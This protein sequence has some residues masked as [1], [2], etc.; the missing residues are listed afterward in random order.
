MDIDRKSSPRSQSKK[1]AAE[2]PAQA[3]LRHTILQQIVEGIIVTDAAGHILFVNEA[4]RRLH[5]VAELGVP[6]EDYSK[7][8]H[9]LT[10][11]GAPYP[12][13]RLPLARAVLGGETVV[14]A[15][16]R[17][18]RPDGTQIV[19][20]GSATPIRAEEGAQSG[21]VLVLRDITERVRAE[22]QLRESEQRF[23]ALADTAPVLIWMSGL[24][25][26]CTY[27][28]KPWLDFT[29][30]TL[31][32][33]R[34]NGWVE[35]VHPDDRDRCLDVYRTSFRARAPF[36]M[37]YRLRRWDGEFRWLLDNGT[38][39]FVDD[40]HFAGYIGSCID[41][42]ERKRA[43]AALIEHETRQRTLLRDIL[44]SVTEGKLILCD[45]AA[46]LP[47][48]LTPVADPITLAPELLRA[49]RSTAQKA[50][51]ARG[52]GQARLQDL[53]TAVSE[54]AMNA[55]V[56]GGGGTTTVCADPAD[57]VQIWIEDTGGGIDLNRLPQATLERGFTTGGGLGHGFFL[58]LQLVDRVYLRTDLGGT[59]VVLEQERVAP[60][61]AWLAG[62]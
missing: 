11:E 52:W 18:Q 55:L 54:A 34:G 56:H 21:A 42:T 5:G 39:R 61:P 38:P 32:Q 43:E 59:T 30:R 31:E 17:I 53:V 44:Q 33:E 16:W 4:A 1:P 45:S 23:H 29:G 24:D 58:M 10:L 3:A 15:E 19:A 13:E 37:E 26:K 51:A 12:P 6:V 60:E 9:L 22:A 47:A 46:E 40:N 41:V 49:A 36:E 35:N 62:R 20:Q 14:D 50:A 25:T 48:P 57:V 27:F 2:E 8:Y 7:T 28:N